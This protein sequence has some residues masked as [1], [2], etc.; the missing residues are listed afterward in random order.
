MP[1]HLC[2]SSRNSFV[3][4]PHTDDLSAVRDECVSLIMFYCRGGG[5]SRAVAYCP[6]KPGSNPQP[7][8]RFVANLFAQGFF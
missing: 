6:S 7:K 2:G 3:L 8:F 5:A 1:I 4:T